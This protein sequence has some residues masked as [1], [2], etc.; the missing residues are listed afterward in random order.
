MPDPRRLAGN[1]GDLVK[2]AVLME[3]VT[4]WGDRHP[5][6]R[7][8]ETHAGYLAYG[9][10]DL[11]LDAADPSR[12]RAL[13][14]VR[15]AL[16]RGDDLGLWGHVTKVALDLDRW[17]GSLAGLSVVAPE[18][19]RLDGFDLGDDQV[20]S[21]DH[22]LRVR[23]RQ[24]D[25]FSGVLGEAPERRDQLVFVDPFWDVDDSLRVRQLLARCPSVVVWAPV[26]DTRDGASLHALGLDVLEVRWA[27]PPAGGLLGCAMG[28]QGV[29]HALWDA[30]KV[31]RRFESAF[32]TEDETR[33]TARNWI[34]G[35]EGPAAYFG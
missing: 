9:P 19:L 6:G 32:A 5:E 17:Y 14:G 25:G 30:W 21:F 26:D 7:Y 24:A 11:D 13:Q 31:Y 16:G 20:R 12:R 15:R 10:E 1:L 23:V 33:L 18:G 2:H 3:V 34:A 35:V 28:F 22:H 27:D 4:R 8:V 29:P